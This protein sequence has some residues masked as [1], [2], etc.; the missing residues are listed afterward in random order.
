MRRRRR[1]RAAVGVLGCAVLTLVAFQA[2]AAHVA[3]AMLAI[4]PP[5]L[6]LLA[7]LMV[8]RSI[9]RGRPAA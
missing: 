8:L 9:Y 6:L 5:I 7:E 4:V 2:A 1:I 3:P